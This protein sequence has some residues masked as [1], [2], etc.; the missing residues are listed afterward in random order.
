MAKEV[1]SIEEAGEYL[2]VSKI[3]LYKACREGKIP[4]TRFGKKYVFFKETL[5]EWL[6]EVTKSKQPISIKTHKAE[7]SGSR[8]PQRGGKPTEEA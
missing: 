4:H 1:M 2:G 5:D 7:G 3:W 6:K 8:R